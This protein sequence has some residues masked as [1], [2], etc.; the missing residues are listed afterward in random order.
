MDV[1]F[2]STAY[3]GR[4]IAREGRFGTV[5]RVVGSVC[6]TVLGTLGKDRLLTGC[7]SG[8]GSESGSLVCS[9]VQSRDRKGAVTGTVFPQIG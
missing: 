6:V 7:P 4:S 3:G 9:N 5:E 2:Q 1:P 8:P